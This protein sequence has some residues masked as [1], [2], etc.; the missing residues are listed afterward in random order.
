[1]RGSAVLNH[2]IYGYTGMN[3][4]YNSDSLRSSEY[5]GNAIVPGSIANIFR[6]VTSTPMRLSDA[7]RIILYDVDSHIISSPAMRA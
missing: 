3:V 6:A 1:M 7:M 5:K 2:G 4:E